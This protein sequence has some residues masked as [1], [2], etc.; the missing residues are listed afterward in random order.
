MQQLPNLADFVDQVIDF[1]IDQG[2]KY[3]KEEIG[4]C[5]QRAKRG[6]VELLKTSAYVFIWQEERFQLDIDTEPPCSDEE[7]PA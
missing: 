5:E 1:V 7:E 6:V 4:M 2:N 3:S